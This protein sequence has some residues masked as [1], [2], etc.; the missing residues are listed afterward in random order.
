ME[1][2]IYKITNLS[3]GYVYVGSAASIKNR[4][5]QHKA[6]L[7]RNRHSNRRLQNAWNKYGQSIFEF[8]LIELVLDKSFLIEREQYWI[9]ILRS[10][11]KPNYN[12]CPIAGS[13]LGVKLNNET[14]YKMSIA[15]I[16]KKQSP[17]AIEK[18]AS[19]HRG[20]KRSIETCTKI[21][22]SIKGR[23]MHE[24]TRLALLLST[25]GR[26]QTNHEKEKRSKIMTGRKFS[27][28]HRTK[29]SLSRMGKTPWLGKKHSEITKLKMSEARKRY[30]E[31]LK[32]HNI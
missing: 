31:K 3:S 15:H 1:S 6:S 21:S 12:I 22:E 25:K 28:E 11:I 27:I 23:K 32:L 4:W 10:A 2:G 5:M 17:E 19:A 14:K 16:G 7:I 30:H 29:I 18:T 13:T 9:D 20:K 24:N 26:K 8:S